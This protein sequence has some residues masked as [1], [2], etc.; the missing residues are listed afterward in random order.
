MRLLNNQVRD[1]IFVFIIKSNRL[2]RENGRVFGRYPSKGVGDPQL[3]GRDPN[4]SRV[5]GF[6]FLVSF[7]GNVLLGPAQGGGN[8]G[9]R[10][11]RSGTFLGGQSNSCK[12]PKKKCEK[13]KRKKSPKSESS[14]GDGRL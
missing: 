12:T 6:R 9:G 2:H 11:P 14:S 3:V 4:R 1:K 5:A 8:Q 7:S 13:K 10:D